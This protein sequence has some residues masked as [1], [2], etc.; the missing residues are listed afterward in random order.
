MA[1]WCPAAHHFVARPVLAVIRRKAT[2]R[3]SVGRG[4]LALLERPRPKQRISWQEQSVASAA[5]FMAFNDQ[6]GVPACRE[7]E[8]W[9][10][11][12]WRHSHSVPVRW[13]RGVAGAE[14]AGRGWRRRRWQWSRWSERRIRNHRQLKRPESGPSGNSV[15]QPSGGQ[16]SPTGNT[17]AQ[18][19]G[20]TGQNSINSPGTGV[21]PGSTGTNR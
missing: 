18:P 19:P 20:S 8:S 5:Y 9:R 12:W 4:L 13:R 10:F 17:A 2:A 3:R 6:H 21:G 1:A 7:Q 11:H 16:S 14:V 15:A